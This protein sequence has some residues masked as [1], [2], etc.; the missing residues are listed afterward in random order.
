MDGTSQ[1][2]REPT[3]NAAGEARTALVTGASR[4]IGASVAMQLA[5]AGM[6]V[7]IN[8]RCKTTRAQG[9][10]EAV[11]YLGRRVLLL[12]ADLTLAEE[13]QHAL[14][15]LRTAWS[16]LDLLILN[17][18]G[19]LE[20]DR[21]PGY[22]ER[23]NWHA[24]VSL[25]R[26][27]SPMMPLGACIVYVTSHLA[28]FHGVKPGYQ[29]YE[30]IAASKRAGE[31]ALRALIPELAAVKVRLLV[32]S[33]DLI[34]GTV[35]PKLLQLQYPDL[36]EVRRRRAGALPSVEQFAA[37]IV[38]VALDDSLPTGHTLFVGSTDWG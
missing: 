17:A 9:V 11:A 23:L 12:P 20:R 27:V 30:P 21:D 18:S 38:R 16:S 19:G 15:T 28:H 7:A 26:Q 6:D 29:E 8:Y 10:A 36:I 34:E 1:D 4:G 33:G 37:V 3:L 5:I 13:V 32:V 14:S 22:A 2:F 24:Q 31:D 25:V 35:T